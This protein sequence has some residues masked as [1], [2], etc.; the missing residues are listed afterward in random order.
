MDGGG[1]SG[2]AEEEDFKHDG[3]E[4]VKR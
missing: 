4:K 2:G 1:G 3:D